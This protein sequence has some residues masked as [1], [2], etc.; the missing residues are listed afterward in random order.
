MY[1]LLRVFILKL[2][3]SICVLP[4]EEEIVKR[5]P[6]ST[7]PDK[8]RTTFL[9]NKLDCLTYKEIAKAL[10]IGVKAVEKRMSLA[11]KALKIEIN[12]S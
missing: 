9:M 7:L 5:S 12:K 3:P 6:L 11:L 10:N 2:V 4:F 1:P 8:Q